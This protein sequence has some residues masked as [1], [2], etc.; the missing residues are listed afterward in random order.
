M[1]LA[2]SLRRVFSLLQMPGTCAFA[3]PSAELGLGTV[4]SFESFQR[5][6]GVNFSTRTTD[7]DGECVFDYDFEVENAAILAD[8]EARAAE[9]ARARAAAATAVE[10]VGAGVGG[11]V[12][13]AE[14][15]ATRSMVTK[16]RR[17]NMLPVF[18]IVDQDV[19]VRELR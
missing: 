7:V 18:G 12:M 1:T 15:N 3:Q 2:Q 6:A 19:A 13:S 8:A 16:A 17:T 4:R 10:A 11:Q 9:E 14:Y 5:W